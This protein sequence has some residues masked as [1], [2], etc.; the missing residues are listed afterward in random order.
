[1]F[2][3]ESDRPQSASQNL[4][5]TLSSER[6]SRRWFWL[7]LIFA[8]IAVLFL[9]VILYNAEPAYMPPGLA[10]EKSVNQTSR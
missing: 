7:L 4:A 2:S 8:V 3:D 6:L 9:A 5:T 10:A 1:M